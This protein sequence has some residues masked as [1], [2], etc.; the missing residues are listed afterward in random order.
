MDAQPA[1]LHT[2]TAVTGPDAERN[3]EA[4]GKETPAAGSRGPQ[5]VREGTMAFTTTD[6]HTSGASVMRVEQGRM[7]YGLREIAAALHC[8]EKSVLRYVAQY[9][10]PAGKIGGR[11]CADEA[12]LREW[13][14]RQIIRLK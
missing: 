3:T 9:G 6:G 4:Q 7:L 10:L 12:R 13:Q 5:M 11:W 14:E 8:S 2:A 1:A